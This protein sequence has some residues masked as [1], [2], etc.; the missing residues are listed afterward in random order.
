MTDKAQRVL[1]LLVLALGALLLFF[2]LDRYDLWGDEVLSFPKG[3]T[4]S[5]MLEWVKWV[6]SQVHPPLYNVVQFFWGAWFVGDSPGGNRLLYALSGFFAL[7]LVYLL[8][9]DLFNH[10]VALIATLLAAT[11]PFL[12][13]YS[14][15]V[16]YYPL[17]GMLVLLTIWTFLRLYRNPSW[18]NWLFFSMSG[19]LLI[20]E[21]Y[22]GWTILL[23]LY[24]YLLVNFSTIRPQIT[25]W[26]L[27]A[28]VMLILFSPWIPVL[29]S[30][31]GKESSPYPE[32]VERVEKDTPRVAQRGFGLAGFA[33]SL[34]IKIGYLGYVFTVGETTYFWNWAV[35]LPII[36]VYLILV[37]RAI[38]LIR[39]R[40]EK[41]HRFLFFVFFVSWLILLILSEIYSV[42]STRAFQLPSKIMFLLPLFL[43]LIAN[44]WSMIKSAP[45]RIALLVVL[46]AGNAYGV[47]NYFRGEQFL[48]P[49]FLVSW[50]QIQADIE[51]EADP[52]DLILTDEEALVHY[53]HTTH[54][55]IEEFGLV[56]A[57]EKVDSVLVDRGPH[58][59]Y[60]VI[61]YRGDEVIVMEG[62]KVNLQLSARYQ[63]VDTWH[64]LP[65]DPEAAPY[66][67]RF[68]GRDPKPYMVEVFIYKVEPEEP[69][70][71]ES[72]PNP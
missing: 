62:M 17:T 21:D 19:A 56:G 7:V 8:G 37:W 31:L 61:R 29:T 27:A 33:S 57:L 13:E 4:F 49:K 66:W 48:N 72:G 55:P 45:L 68:L 63:M 28:L 6:P 44:G 60:L 54:S 51:E 59:V 25:K 47:S 3:E 23:V 65:L 36:F 71:N 32:H 64:Y 9:K 2:D 30:Q 22:L 16:R 58:H 24:L 11:S 43:L 10:R 41:D 39:K 46:M 15:M 18:G 67:K 20:Y 70:V 42:F 50:E 69:A 35:V 40:G 14:R 12:V 53:L 38:A 34:V 5:Q 52:Q 26:L 1:L